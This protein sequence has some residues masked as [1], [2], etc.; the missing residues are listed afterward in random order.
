MARN[1]KGN[2][3]R[4]AHARRISGRKRQSVVEGRFWESNSLH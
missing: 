3:P 1:T 2:Y 4:A